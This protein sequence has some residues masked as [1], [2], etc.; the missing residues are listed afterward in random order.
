MK[1]LMKISVWAS[2][3][4]LAAAC[5]KDFEKINT[6]PDAYATAPTTNMMA[7]IQ[8]R[9]ATQMGDI[10]TSPP[11]TPMATS[12]IRSISAASR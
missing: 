8:S 2:L 1:H 10:T 3:L 9:T 7:Y 12:G 6:D 5:T 11:T 4:V